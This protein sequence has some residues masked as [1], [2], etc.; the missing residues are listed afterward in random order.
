MTEML[1]EQRYREYIAFRRA[2]TAIDFGGAALMSTV[3]LG[4]AEP[5]HVE[6]SPSPEIFQ[7]TE[8]QKRFLGQTPLTQLVS[9]ER[10]ANPLDDPDRVLLGYSA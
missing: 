3:T 9:Q 10:E 5:S 8:R 6:F 4:I 2:E 1:D 7:P